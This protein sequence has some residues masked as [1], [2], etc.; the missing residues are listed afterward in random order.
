M[1]AFDW[2][3]FNGIL[4]LWVLFSVA[5]Q[6][7]ILTHH[8][9]VITEVGSMVARLLDHV[10]VSVDCNC[11]RCLIDSVPTGDYPKEEDPNAWKQWEES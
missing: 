3:L 5:R 10:G 1:A 4:L 2:N 11:Q 8:R 6:R 9:H 7:M